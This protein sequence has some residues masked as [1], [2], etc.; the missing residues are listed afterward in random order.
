MLY[1][2]TEEELNNRKM[3]YYKCDIYSLGMVLIKDCIGIKISQNISTTYALGNSR[4]KND[5]S[6]ICEQLA[7]YMIKE[8]PDDQPD[9]ECLI[10]NP[11]FWKKATDYSS[12]LTNVKNYLKSGDLT[13]QRIKAIEQNAIAKLFTSKDKKKNDWLCYLEDN[14]DVSREIEKYLNENSKKKNSVFHL[15]QLILAIVSLIITNEY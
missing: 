9:T 10:K 1:N 11:F 2:K 6:S 7:M 14:K 13:E 15:V 12:F 4:R 3:E 8:N 5:I